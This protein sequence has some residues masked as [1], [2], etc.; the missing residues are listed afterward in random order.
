[1][2]VVPLD[3]TLPGPM[4]AA[5]LAALRQTRLAADP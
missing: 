3:F 2:W 5:M 1:V 4:L